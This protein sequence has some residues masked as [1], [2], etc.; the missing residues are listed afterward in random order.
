MRP[1]V[2]HRW[3]ARIEGQRADVEIRVLHRPAAAGIERLVDPDR[4]RGIERVR[5]VRIDREGEDVP[6]L[7]ALVEPLPGCARV[8]AAEKPVVRRRVHRRG[9]RRIDHQRP[10]RSLARTGPPCGPR[11]PRHPRSGRCPRCSCRRRGVGDCEDRRRSS[12]RRPASSAASARPMSRRRPCCGRSGR[13]RCRRR[14]LRPARR[15]HRC[16]VR[17]IRRWPPPRRLPRRRSCR[18]LR[19]RS[20]RRACASRD[21]PPGRAR[22]GSRGPGCAAPRLRPNRASGKG[23][24]R[25]P[26]RRWT[27]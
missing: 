19:C 17:S 23:L 22:N 20:R 18:R 7:Q 3:R 5:T 12:S 27:A 26:H 14:P 11:S 1:G 10:D 24:A 4:R 16:G 15:R 6:A 2:Q 8:V 13:P 21:P 9:L 25:S